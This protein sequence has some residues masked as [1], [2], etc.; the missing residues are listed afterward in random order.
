[1]AS[2]YIKSEIQKELEWV[3][4]EIMWLARRPRV[5]PSSARA[6]YTHIASERL[7]RKI[8]KFTGMVSDRAI[9]D[10]NNELRLE[11]YKRIQTKLTQLVKE[12]LEGNIN[13]PEE[14]IKTVIECE[15]VHIV[16]LHENYAAMKSKGDY[17]RAGIQLIK[18]DDIELEIKR[19]LWDKMIRGKVSNAD[20]YKV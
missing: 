12:H 9:S 15:K 3:Y 6:W 5:T 13:D 8:R 20:L 19:D 4:E 16:T 10:F 11:H 1:M 18:W 14:F 7:K 17:V 2:E